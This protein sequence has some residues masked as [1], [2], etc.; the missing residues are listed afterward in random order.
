MNIVIFGPPLAGKGTQ[1]KRIINDFELTHLSTGD[2]L[3]DEQAQ[4]TELGIKASEYSNK[5]L[6]AP[7]ELVAQIV[8]KFYHSNKLNKGILFD[9]YP[10]NTEQ[11]KHLINVIEKDKSKIDRII[12]LKVPKEELLNR[13]I[14]RAKEENRTDDKDSKIV[15]TRI[16]EFENL[17]I[18]AIKFMNNLGIETIE[19]DG[20]LPI[21]DIYKTIKSGL[22]LLVK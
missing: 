1:C 19:I 5:G 4:K 18:P 7:D 16:N 21:E 12:Y 9:G 13:A 6:L 11:A 20:S 14:K 17:T 3:R 8:E 15:Q 2:V 22:E 10:R